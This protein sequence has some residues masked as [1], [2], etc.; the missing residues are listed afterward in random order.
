MNL[1][2]GQQRRCGWRVAQVLLA[3]TS[4]AH[5][6][7]NTRR[8]LPS[9]T[10]QSSQP[11]AEQLSPQAGRVEPAP[12]ST[13]SPPTS[14][15]SIETCFENFEQSQVLLKEGALIEAGQLAL[16]C[17]Q[18]CP[19]EIMVE[20]RALHSQTEH[21]TPTA[22]LLARSERGT[23]AANVR[24]FIDGVERPHVLGE[25][26]PLNPG[27]HVIV[28]SRDDGFRELVDIVVRRSEKRRQIR[29]VV[30][31]SNPVN[32][33]P[34][35][36]PDSRRRPPWPAI[37]AFS[38]GGA[39]FAGMAAAGIVA[40]D[41][42]AALE[43]DCKPMS[44]PSDEV[45]DRAKDIEAWV[46]VG[47]VTLAV[48]VIGAAAGLGLLVWEL[49]SAKNPTQARVLSVTPTAHGASAVLSGQF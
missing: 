31:E 22:L 1:A 11:T 15:Q 6:E 20:C 40:L 48:G 9:N 37:A 3:V 8:E 46:T 19:A 47:D 12:D 38:A 36:A 41:K 16:R 42:R 13:I 14:E 44:C 33:N 7:P 10:P 2:R 35:T 43:D 32:L 17:S 28:F 25:E 29:V 5:A 39:G 4:I 30:P 49:R 21:D 23:D 24:V 34:A 18:S 27:P 26:I 45:K